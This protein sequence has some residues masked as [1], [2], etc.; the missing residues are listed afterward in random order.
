MEATA[1]VGALV[2]EFVRTLGIVAATVARE[3]RKRGL[4]ALIRLCVMQLEQLL[5]HGRM[6]LFFCYAC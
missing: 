5:A 6:I 4:R 2:A 1:V 3:R